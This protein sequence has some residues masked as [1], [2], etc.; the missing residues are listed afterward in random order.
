M[1]SIDLNELSALIERTKALLDERQ[2]G[3]FTWN[4]ALHAALHDLHVM[5]EPCAENQP[6]RGGF[7]GSAV[8]QPQH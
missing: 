3:L 1:P 4:E 6:T 7:M 2:V 8:G 5:T